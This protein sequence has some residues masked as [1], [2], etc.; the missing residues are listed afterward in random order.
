[1]GKLYTV[2][3]GYEAILFIVHIIYPT[4]YFRSKGS[5]DL[6]IKSLW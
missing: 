6:H 4:E 5:L 3:Y 2:V 1:M